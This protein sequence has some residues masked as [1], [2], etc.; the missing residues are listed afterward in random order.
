[1]EEKAVRAAIR[2]LP[3]TPFVSFSVAVNASKENV[4]G[5]KVPALRAFAKRIAKETD[6][7]TWP[8]GES[9]ELDLVH[10]E[11]VLANAKDEKK[12][13]RFAER[14]LAKTD[15][16]ALVDN[17]ASQFKI[18]NLD[19]AYQESQKF[20]HSS[21]PWVRRF[22]Y[23]H[24]ITS[25]KR[26]DAKAITSLLVL[27]EVPA[28]A[29]AEAWLVAEGLIY[30]GPELEAFLKDCPDRSLV[31]RSIQ[32]AVESYRIPSEMKTLLSHFRK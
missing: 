31:N 24:L 30:H 29:K 4:L 16:W 6:P 7:S 15:G 18:K 27:Y 9:F 19:L 3:R 32:K 10:E 5:V 23:S 22:A 26:L 8:V 21:H 2:A 11:I 13:Y 12:R 20:S 14:F 28:V 25:A 17:L 1:M